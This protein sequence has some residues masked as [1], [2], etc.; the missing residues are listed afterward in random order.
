MP[1]VP[2][3]PIDPFYWRRPRGPIPSLILTATGLIMIGFISNI[4]TQ[5]Y[6]RQNIKHTVLTGLAAVFGLLLLVL[7][8]I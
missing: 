5:G 1:A 2:A 7:M 8:M 6:Y 3:T 4:L